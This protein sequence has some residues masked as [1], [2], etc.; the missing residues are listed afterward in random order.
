MKIKADALSLGGY[1]LPTDGEWEYACRAGAE[2]SRYY[3]ASMDLLGQYAWYAANSDDHAWLCASV[4][5]NDLG[6]FDMLG[7]TF[8]WCQEVG[9]V[10]QPDARGRVTEPKAV[11]D[12][13]VDDTNPRT[14]RGGGFSDRAPSV[15][16]AARHRDAPAVH[17]N[18]FGFRPARTLP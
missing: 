4:L 7:N 2:T 14:L 11:R 5:P 18:T 16:S 8:E 17:T 13:F 10:Y 1:R 12:A 3:G 9:T 6:L 15:R